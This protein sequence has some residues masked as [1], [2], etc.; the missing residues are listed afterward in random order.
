M[1]TDF[2]DSWGIYGDV[3]GEPVNLSPNEMDSF[4]VIGKAAWIPN[5]SFFAW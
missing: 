5:E 3:S 4:R 1:V 2:C